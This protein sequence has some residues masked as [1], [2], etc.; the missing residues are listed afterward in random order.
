MC[1]AAYYGGKA[2][3]CQLAGNIHA[4][5]H[6][7]GAKYHIPHG[8]AIALSLLPVMNCQKEKCREKLARLSCYCGLSA[9]ADSDDAACEKVLDAIRSLIGLCAFEKMPPIPRVSAMV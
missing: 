3:N 4:F 8:N 2:I 7:I 6:T 5:A 1:L 9:P